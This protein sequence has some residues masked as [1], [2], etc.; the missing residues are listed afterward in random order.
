MLLWGKQ[1]GLK[2]R[3]PCWALAAFDA[4]FGRHFGVQYVVLRDVMKV[5]WGMVERV[6]ARTTAR[7]KVKARQAMHGDMFLQSWNEHIDCW[8]VG[9][10]S[11][12]PFG[13]KAHDLWRWSCLI[14]AELVKPWL[15][16][17][18]LAR[19][20]SGREK[21]DKKEGSGGQQCGAQIPGERCSEL[22]LI[23][24]LGDCCAI[25]MLYRFA[26]CHISCECIKENDA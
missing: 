12:Q 10:G 4:G 25:D 9:F 3:Y 17:N 2:C 14:F 16:C 22:V 24:V 21:T 11:S 15:C 13:H 20:E 5:H 23:A 8:T 6:V 1:L 26:C 18:L 7:A 19:E